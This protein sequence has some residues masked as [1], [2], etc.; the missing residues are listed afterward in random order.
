MNRAPV[1]KELEKTRDELRSQLQKI[2]SAILALA[3]NGR[4]RR[5]SLGVRRRIGAGIR[6]AWAE[7]KAK[8]K[9][10]LK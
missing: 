3:R 2:E 9:K 7:R 4:R 1:V 6:K 8:M 10:A 5:M